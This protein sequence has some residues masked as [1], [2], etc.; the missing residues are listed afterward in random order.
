MKKI[1]VICSF[2]LITV[3]STGASLMHLYYLKSYKKEFKL[4]LK[5]N[6]ER[7]N[8][9]IIYINP[10]ELYTNSAKITWEDE[11]KEVLYKGVLYDI[12]E[13]KN[14]GIK[15][16]LIAVSD[17]Q[18]MFLKKEFAELF[19]LNSHDKTRN[20]GHLLKNFFSLKCVISQPEQNCFVHNEFSHNWKSTFAFKILTISISKESPPPELCI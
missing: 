16:A 12:I 5:Q 17:D 19:D 13:I 18:E 3:F 6:K 11:N 10:S 1:T 7:N 14:A 4:F 8:Q 9:S 2:I 15:V 20:S